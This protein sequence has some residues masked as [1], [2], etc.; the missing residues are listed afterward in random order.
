MK[1]LYPQEG[2]SAHAPLESGFCLVTCFERVDYEKAARVTLQ[3]RILAN[4]A[5]FWQA[6]IN[7]I[8]DEPC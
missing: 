1:I 3:W 8:S 4:I 7:I 6:I 2:R 5:S